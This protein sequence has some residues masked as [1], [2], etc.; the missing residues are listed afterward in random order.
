MARGRQPQTT[1][2]L[3]SICRRGREYPGHAHTAGATALR[4]ITIA[5]AAALTRAARC[6]LSRCLPSAWNSG[7]VRRN[8]TLVATN[9]FLKLWG[10]VKAAS[11]FEGWVDVHFAAKGNLGVMRATAGLIPAIAVS[12]MALAIGSLGVGSARAQESATH[13]TPIHKTRTRKRPAPKTIASPHR[14]EKRRKEATGAITRTPPRKPNAGLCGRTPT[15][16]KNQPRRISLNRRSPRRRPR[17]QHQKPLPIKQLGQR[18]SNRGR[19]RR[20][21]PLRVANRP[22]AAPKTATK[23]APKPTI[24]PTTKPATKTAAGYAAKAATPQRRG[25]IL[26]HRKA[27]PAMCHG[28]IRCGWRPAEHRRQLIAAPP[29]ALANN[30]QAPAAPAQSSDK[31]NGNDAASDRQAA[32]PIATAVSDNDEMPV[33]LLLA[34]AISM[35]VAGILVRRIVKMLFAR[36]RRIN[37]ERREPV[38][39]T[40]SA[41]ERTITLPVAHQRDLAPGWVDRL[42]EDVQ[43]S[44]RHLLRTLE[45]QAA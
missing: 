8:N 19:P 7:G 32:E 31:A 37:P 40:N 24:K 22:K 39:R 17:R 1:A 15:R 44:L 14:A 30:Q 27:A 36:R 25:P 20:R 3:R 18:A 43:E 11:A 10:T 41:G 9:F 28:R 12:V 16:R 13:K 45:R 34:L 21:G 26:R 38:L 35:L 29:P 33:G 6:L 23:A 42:D 2:N 4:V 5:A